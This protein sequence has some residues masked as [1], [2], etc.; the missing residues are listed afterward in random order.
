MLTPKDNSERNAPSSKRRLLYSLCRSILGIMAVGFLA[1]VAMGAGGVFW[2]VAGDAASLSLRA[3]GSLG[4][5]SVVLLLLV[6]IAF[7]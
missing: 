7:K 2:L 6:T 5:A 1:L 3:L 4:I